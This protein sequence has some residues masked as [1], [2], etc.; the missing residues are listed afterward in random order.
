MVRQLKLTELQSRLRALGE[1]PSFSSK[2]AQLQHRCMTCHAVV[3]YWESKNSYNI[4]GPDSEKLQMQLDALTASHGQINPACVAASIPP[5]VEFVS[6]SP[7][8]RKLQKPPACTIQLGPPEASSKNTDIQ[9]FDDWL[10]WYGEFH[11]TRLRESQ[12]SFEALSDASRNMLPASSLR[13]A[14]LTVLKNEELATQSMYR[15]VSLESDNAFK[16][17]FASWKEEKQRQAE[18]RERRLVE[19]RIRDAKA[20]RREKEQLS[21]ELRIERA[22]SERLETALRESQKPPQQSA[23]SAR[24][25]HLAKRRR[26]EQDS[27]LTNFSGDLCEKINQ[28]REARLITDTEA[29]IMHQDRKVG[30]RAAH[31]PDGFFGTQLS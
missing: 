9:T 24:A 17:A 8:S 22:R 13:D 29:C 5:E 6:A 25:E 27:R 2:G 19:Q 30:N 16:A 3:N 28:A 14:V 21:E 11:R 4:Q 18:D 31:D 20:D 7:V 12:E 23:P 10:M 26:L 15:Q 1:E